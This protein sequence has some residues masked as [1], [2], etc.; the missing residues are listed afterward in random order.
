VIHTINT[1]HNRPQ[2]SLVTI[3]NDKSTCFGR[4]EQ[5]RMYHAAAVR[6]SRDQKPIRNGVPLWTETACRFP[7]KPP[8]GL[9]RNRLS[10]TPKFAARPRRHPARKK[11]RPFRVRYA[12]ASALFAT[13]VRW[14][15]S[16]SATVDG[17][18][19]AARAK[20]CCDHAKSA[21]AIGISRRR[22]NRSL[23]KW[24]RTMIDHAAL[25]GLPAPGRRIICG[26]RRSV[27]GASRPLPRIPTI[28]SGET[29]RKP[30]FLLNRDQ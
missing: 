7:P 20:S 6:Q 2:Q 5:D 29:R 15:R 22:G 23:T 14:P 30:T 3:N 19:C 16:K 28:V 26:E 13:G 21:R 18:T 24:Q 8:A 1:I 27:Y 17:P 12:S 10:E 11:Y 9:N 4:P 25:P